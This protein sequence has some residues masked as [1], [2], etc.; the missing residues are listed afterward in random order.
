MDEIVPPEAFAG[1]PGE[2]PP[3]GASN[4]GPD[5]GSSPDPSGSKRPPAVFVGLGLTAAAGIGVGVYASFF[6]PDPPAPITCSL[7]PIQEPIRDGDPVVITGAVLGQDE[8][9]WEL[10]V[11]G[12]RIRTS[13]GSVRETLH[14]EAGAHTVELR[15]PERSCSQVVEFQVLPSSCGALTGQVRLFPEGLQEPIDAWCDHFDDPGGDGNWLLVAARTA[16]GDLDHVPEI[17]K[18]TPGIKLT[19]VPGGVLRKPEDGDNAHDL[20]IYL[21]DDVWEVLRETHTQV[22]LR[23]HGTFDW[24]ADPGRRLT[25]ENPDQLLWATLDDLS[26][27]NCQELGSL[28]NTPIVFHEKKGC[29]GTGSDYAG[30]GGPVGW[31]ARPT[32]SGGAAGGPV[33]FGSNGANH[34]EPAT[35]WIYIR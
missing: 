24:G 25:W 27:A 14:P 26:Q 20:G 19:P 21:E 4:P 10:L 32:W 5:P 31:A 35:L 23:G 8:A 29:T 16:S 1:N 2:R 33:D 15:D 9:P 3:S 13:A 17:T 34:M 12:H 11:D 7:D 30:F 18:A 28:G 22:L 6:Q